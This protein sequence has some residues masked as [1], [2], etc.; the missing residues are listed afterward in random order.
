MSTYSSGSRYK[1]RTL[2]NIKEDVAEILSV[3]IYL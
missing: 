1:L 3:I 2:D